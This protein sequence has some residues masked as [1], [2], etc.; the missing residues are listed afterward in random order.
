MLPK[1]LPEPD[2]QDAPP[3]WLDRA[4]ALLAEEGCVVLTGPVGPGRRAALA[5]LLRPHEGAVVCARIPGR[6]EPEEIIRA[7]G[8]ALS[9]PVRGDLGAIGAAL[10]ALPS[11]I[12]ALDDAPPAP[13]AAALRNLRALAPAARFLIAAESPVADLAH[14]SAPKRAFEAP[15]LSQLEGLGHAARDLAHL[16]WGLPTDASLGL[17]E[18][19]RLP[20]PGALTLVPEALPRLAPLPDAED[21][22]TRLARHAAALLPL[23]EGQILRAWDSEAH[24]LLLRFLARHHPDDGLATQAAAAG[25]RLIAAAGQA[26]A[27]RE[28]LGAAADRAPEPLA[29]LLTWAEGDILMGFGLLHE[30]TARHREAADAFQRLGDEARRAALLHGTASQ[31]HALGFFEEARG[32]AREAQRVS[33]RRGDRSASLGPLRLLAELALS[34]GELVSADTLHD[35]AEA[36]AERAGVDA[37]VLGLSRA[38]LAIA[39]GSLPRARD[40]LRALDTPGLPPAMCLAIQRRR[41]D[42]LLRDGRHDEVL[43]AVPEVV[44]GL[45]RHGQRAAAAAAMRLQADALCLARHPAEAAEAYQRA[46]YEAGRAGDLHGARRTVTHLLTLERSGKDARRVEELLGLLAQLDTEL[47]DPER[48]DAVALERELGEPQETAA[49]PRP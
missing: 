32:R 44:H 23:A 8:E 37:E 25:A 33:L 28:L 2:P 34:N 26:G 21:A 45:R 19:L 18:A 14:L 16:P 24:V 12:V 17:P 42:L 31:L 22:A 41:C 47:S 7:V 9:L 48:R 20:T 30:A 35:H 36:E 46:L 3:S 15:A 4:R 38:S 40:I 1:W 43:E 10:G 39:R 11:P 27:A 29:P 5:A 49:A 6:E 13:T